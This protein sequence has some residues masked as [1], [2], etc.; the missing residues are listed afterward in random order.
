MDMR[1]ALI[2]VLVANLFTSLG[3]RDLTP[4]KGKRKDVFG[5]TDYKN[6]LHTG[7]QI[8]AGPT[9]MLTRRE[10]KNPIYKTTED[11][12]PMT[13]VIDPEGKPGVFIEVGLA[14][15]T[16][17]SSKLEE[18]IGYRFVSY[19][20]WGLGFKTLGGTEKTTIDYYNMNGEISGTSEGTGDFNNGYLYGRFAAHKLF[21]LGEEKKYFI[22]NGFGLS[23]DFALMNGS[24]EYE[25]STGGQPEFISNQ[26]A[27]KKPLSFQ[28][29]YGLGF[30]IRLNRRSQIIPGINVPLFGFY[31]W[32]KGGGTATKWFSSNY[33]PF[34]AQLKFIYLFEK[35]VKGCNTPGTEEDRKRNQE[36]MQGQ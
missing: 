33:V 14:H 29:Q 31:E 20:D 21:Y 4:G 10:S 30:G 1:I 11:G 5:T 17:K 23:F 2:S 7:L 9:F 25:W 28:F 34:F 32:R 22:D 36:F 24:K 26:Q 16:K 8:T 27:F 3:Q 19:Y 18:A 12:R 35:K 6:Y 13:Y 15:F